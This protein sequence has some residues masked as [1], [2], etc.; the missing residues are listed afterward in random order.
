VFLLPPLMSDHLRAWLLVVALLAW[1]GLARAQDREQGEPG[2]EPGVAPDVLRKIHGV[3]IMGSSDPPGRIEALVAILAP[4]GSTF[5]PSGAADR[6]GM[7][8]GTVPRIKQVLAALG[9][10]ADVTPVPDGD[11]LRLHLALRALDRVRRIY[12]TGNQPFPVFRGV[13][14]EDIIGKLSFRPGQKLPL[15]GPERD[16]FFAAQADHIREFLRSQGYWE[17][18]VRPELHDNHKTPAEVDLV[19]RVNL[20]PAYPLGPLEVTGATVIPAGSIADGFHHSL[21]Y[22][23]G[24]L[25]QPFRLVDLRDDEKALVAR[26]RKIGFPGVRVRDDFKPESPET[27]IDRQAKN[28]RLHLEI[29]ERRH[30][31][32]AFEGNHSRSSF[33]LLDVLTLQSHGAYDD[34]EAAA[35]AAAIEKDY[36][37]HGRMLVKVTWRREQLSEDSDRLVFVIAEGP[38]LK[39]REVA[40]SGNRALATSV[41]RD[42][43]RTKPYPWLGALGLGQGGYASMRQLAL[44]QQGLVDYY[45]EVGYPGTKV[46]VEIAPGPGLWRPVVPEP[47]ASDPAWRDATSLHVRFAIVEAPLVTVAKAAIECV[48]PGERLP[49]DDKFFLRSLRTLVGAPFQPALVRRDE[50]RLKRALGDQGYRYAGVEASTIRHGD[51][52]EVIWQVRLGPQVRIGPIFFRGN[53]LTTDDIIL[54]WAELRT[55]DLLTTSGLERAQRNLAL[56]QLFNNPNPLSFPSTGPEDA[57]VPMVV[58]V[59]ERNDHYGVFRVGMGGSTDQAAPGSDIPGL[60]AVGAYQHRNLFGHG[61][62]FTSEGRYGSTLKSATASYLDPRLLGSL[63]RLGVDLAYIQQATLRLG[64][65]HTGTGSI[66]LARE[67]YSGLDGTISYNLRDTSRTEL[68]DRSA[69]SGPFID[70][71]TVRLGTFVS[72]LSASLEWQRLDHPLI[73]SRGFKIATGVEVALPALSLGE[74]QDTF[75]KV[76]ARGLSVVPLL[77]WLSLR[78]TL[79]YDQGV[80]LGG[81]ALLPKVE[82][83]YAGGDTTIRGYELDFALTETV[84]S[85]ATDGMTYVQYLPVGGDLR[86]LQNI[87]LQFP[88]FRPIY[89][90]LFLDSG[91]VGYYLGD[92]RPGDFR[93]GIGV[94]PLIL[95]LPVGDISL[96]FAVPINRRP[97]DDTWRTHFNVGLMF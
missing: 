33:A 53:F 52:I 30:V 17:A 73:P 91:V 44:D 86:I 74:G 63:V 40:F 3:A 84:R 64:D 51:Q 31:E 24:M 9:Y 50:V 93:H 27:S 1:P 81:A 43:V 92:I 79:R 90:S 82:R 15:A 32:V 29:R 71:Q 60:Y 77:P 58:E 97:G 2:P 76:F 14:Q 62:T 16:S 95:K 72:S 18:E 56:S 4:P 55:G 67:I 61:W 28:V 11:G 88:I 6:A 38:E 19:I 70:Q 89:G 68:L 20:G 47:A 5:V 78:Y 45:A 54:T 87:D 7:P 35:S 69:E 8:I 13:R 75:V 26:Y 21:W 49:H 25:P 94:S 22:T 39:V 59:E 80:P 37:E 46:S 34:V 96:S 48:V 57:V 10:V 41:L 85:P 83:Y 42:Q 65:L 12:V 66:S 23:L 36:H